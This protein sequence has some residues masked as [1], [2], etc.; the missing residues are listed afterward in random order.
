MGQ[1][2]PLEQYR[3]IAT[4]DLDEARESVAHY[5]WT[6]RLALNGT[7]E[8]FDT[9]FH[10]APL[11][12]SSLNFV[13]YGADLTVDAGEPPHCYMIK[14][15]LRGGLTVHRGGATYAAAAGEAV[16]TGPDQYL[17]LRFHPGTDLFVF[18]VPNGLMDERAGL[19]HGLDGPR[20]PGFADRAV[21]MDGPLASFRRALFLLRDEFDA[22]ASL[23]GSELGRSD[24]EEFLLAALLRAWPGAGNGAPASGPRPR[25]VRRVIDFICANDDAPVRMTDLVAVS[26]LGVSALYDAFRSHVG[27]TP[28]QFLRRR[29][30]MAARRA[31]ADPA[32]P[33]TVTE[34]A[35]AHGFNHFGRFS[36]IYRGAFGETPAVTRRRALH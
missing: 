15:I 13:R 22:D 11:R 2:L 19:L 6:H 21:P 20:R 3:V 31:L 5:F 24:Y 4:R 28:M 23:L 35:L 26:G 14:L 16:V 30:L 9:R 32:D 7:S 8:R 10:H 33:R 18:K 17:K 29:R 1:P 25:S 36:V 27:C 34:I 12:A